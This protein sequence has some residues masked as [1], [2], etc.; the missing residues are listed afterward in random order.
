[1]DNRT[2]LIIALGFVLFLIWQMWQQDYGQLS[3][4]PAPGGDKEVTSAPAEIPSIPPPSQE[5][6]VASPSTP[7]SA[8]DKQGERVRVQTDTLDVEIDTVGGDIE[9][10]RLLKYPVS[11]DRKDEP[12][13]LLDNS[14]ALVFITQGGL[15]SNA[16]APDHQSV[17]RAEKSSYEL[18]GGEESLQVKLNWESKQGLAVTKIYTFQRGSYLIDLRYE[19]RNNGPERW[20]GWLYSQ[21]QRR[22]AKGSRGF[23]PT[24]TG[25]VVSSPEK[26]YEKIKFD[27]MQDTPLDRT[28]TGGWAAMLQHYFVAAIIPERSTEY[29]YYSMA[30][31][32]ERY[33]I[34]VLGPELR[35]GQGEQTTTGLKLYVGPKNQQVLEQIAPGLELTVDY[36]WLWFI[37][38]PLFLLLKWF[39]GLTHNWG[40]AIIFT[41][42]L[43]KLAFFH[44]SATSY[45]S[46]A[47]LRKLQPRMTAI[48]ERYGDDRQ[49]A[50]QA[51]M[52]LYRQEKVNPMGGCLPIIVQIPVFIALY[53]VLLESVELRQ[54]SFMFW[55][56]DLSIPDPYFILPLLMGIT[57]YV[58]QKLSPAPADPI[59]QKVF[60]Y[61]PWIFTLS[62]ALFPSG[63]VLYWVVSNM[64]SIVQQWVITRKYGDMARST[65]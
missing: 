64:I 43:V 25:A 56:N 14:E 45:K 62:F 47:K 33:V 7:G 48:R 27:A 59:Q 42:L 36:G 49:R 2:I 63:L 23:I 46:M 30:R 6:Q 1:M 37:A 61:L 13:T 15:R 11:L 19:I 22:Y 41:T 10:A 40:W 26:R 5:P 24:Y 44:L 54:A 20:S 29:H 52:E 60:Q 8:L 50:G 53:W 18:S 31:P 12:F 4:P 34:G 21:L 3:P 9:K 57:M 16:E 65:T 55:L 51:V 17:Y 58:Q 39:H 32:D 28:I 38:K 35:I